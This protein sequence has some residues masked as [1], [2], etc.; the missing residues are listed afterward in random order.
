MYRTLLAI[1][2]VLGLSVAQA[3]A[4]SSPTFNPQ[5]HVYVVPSGWSPLGVS[6]D[7]IA[8][9]EHTAAGLHYPFYVVIDRGD[10]RTKGDERIEGIAQ[11][12][13]AQGFQSSTSQLFLLSYNPRGFR[14]HVGDA[15][16]PAAGINQDKMDTYTALFKAR[17]QLG[18]VRDP[19][20]A[21]Q[22]I[23][24]QVDGDLFEGNDPA[25]MA[26]RA[27][28]A[29]QAQRIK[30]LTEA[31]EKLA[32]RLA[33]MNA[34]LA[35]PAYLDG[36][37]GVKLQEARAAVR[38]G[39]TVMG[40]D[41]ADAMIAMSA[42]L[43]PQEAAIS[44]VVEQAVW[45]EVKHR[46][47]LGFQLLLALVLL[48][49]GGAF[50]VK[51]GRRLSS[52]RSRFADEYKEWSRKVDAA[53]AK[54]V[55]FQDKKGVIA[56]S[57]RTGATAALLGQVMSLVDGIYIAT[58]GM[59][60]RLAVLKRK[61]DMAHFFNLKP[62]EEALADLNQPFKFDTQQIQDELF[63]PD[64][65]IAELTPVGFEAIYAG[66][67]RQ[68]KSGW[69]T[70]VAASQQA[71]RPVEESLDIV[72]FQTVLEE[73]Q[74]LPVPVPKSFWADHSSIKGVESLDYY[75]RLDPVAYVQALGAQAIADN[76]VIDT[77]RRLTKV[78][79]STNDTPSM[80]GIAGSVV[81]RE[82]SAAESVIKMQAIRGALV[83]LIVEGRTS[84]DDIE[85]HADRV[86][87][88]TR[89]VEVKIAKITSA[90][91]QIEPAIQEVREAQATV[92][93]R[94]D[95]AHVRIKEAEKVHA[96]V[97]R[98][99]EGQ[100]KFIEGERKLNEARWL[101]DQHRHLEAYEVAQK[102]LAASKAAI[103]AF[104][105]VVKDC[106]ELDRQKAAY[107]GARRE[108][109]T[110]ESR[111]RNGYLR[112][113]YVP[114]PHLVVIDRPVDYGAAMADVAAYQSRVRREQEEADRRVQAQ[115]D[116]DRASRAHRHTSSYSSGSDSSNNPS[117]SY[118]SGSDSGGGGSSF[119][120]GSDS[121]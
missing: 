35:H 51:R 28:A 65:K 66:Q 88:A 50:V 74:A 102:A 6:Q 106:D 92:R 40:E 100:D 31:R 99:D 85:A 64:T 84:I 103:R 59:E 98:L 8:A 62:I 37:S 107:E 79:R 63:E 23:M 45:Q 7:G 76:K 96:K 115:E 60:S 11:A 114:P 5:T 78:I 101:L 33:H 117:S 87:K 54:Y 110:G 42:A 12:W 10:G 43:A 95:T 80:A 41:N 39:T 38:R 27:A 3:R 1:L 55:D 109:R 82:N 119:S 36:V 30:R 22:A 44:E 52:L 53:L 70:L 113:A 67:Y 58:K 73:V 118:S 19:A 97:P 83:A 9:M 61:A 104:E 56:L 46:I 91:A 49:S 2:L 81:D 29:E 17:V 94:L 18:T 112:Q 15:L 120:S 32:T 72:E 34:I 105:K 90:M 13:I 121:W 14:L 69:D 16:K 108:L 111:A 93:T 21:I 47:W 20:G 75:R 25:K 24:T 77:L 116:A 71:L 4:E 86:M 26:A 57:S 48:V 89:E 68:A